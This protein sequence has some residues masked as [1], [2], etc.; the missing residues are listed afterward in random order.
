V[1]HIAN[2]LGEWFMENRRDFPWRS[3]RSP[4]RVWISEIMLQQT[5]ASVVVP[6]FERWMAQFPDVKALYMA[7][8]EQ[9]IKVWEGLGY[10]SR[11]R[12]LHAAARQ[13]V[14]QFGGEIPDTKESLLSLQGFGPYTTNA[15]LSFGF[16][17]RAVPLDGNVLRVMTRYFSI[18]ESIE[19]PAVRRSVE[20]CADGI[21]DLHTPWVT[22]E[23]LIELGALICTP[24][25]Q[26]PLC[27]LQAGCLAY[28]EGKAEVLPIK[29]AREAITL[30]QRTV[31]VIEWQGWVL[32]KKQEAKK[33]M[34]DLYEF[35]FFEQ[36]CEECTMDG[37]E[38]RVI[39]PLTR[40]SHTF[41]RYKALLFP[42]W[43][44]AKE[45]YPSTSHEWV[46]RDCL[47]Q[48]PFSAGHRKIADEWMKVSCQRVV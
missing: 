30:L 19:K 42:L 18:A 3:W 16:H 11:A 43:M 1:L 33:I 21:L 8:F 14:E 6:Y 25:P 47:A 12:N 4:Y 24:R 48:L 45:K 26:C 27:P 38:L 40:R 39:R 15:V 9:V 20:Q 32:I 5:R 44:E 7:S 46:F 31:F 41:T 35:P 10:Y 28:R 17:R 2:I 36:G 34:A 37:M 13:I 29:R 22:A 23:A